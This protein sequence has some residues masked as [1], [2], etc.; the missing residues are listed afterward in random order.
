MDRKKIIAISMSVSFIATAA[1][2]YYFYFQGNQASQTSNATGK[3]QNKLELKTPIAVSNNIENSSNNFYYVQD[4]KNSEEIKKAFNEYTNNKSSLA[5]NKQLSW[6]RIA[7][8][9]KEEVSLDDLSVAVGFKINDKISTLFNKNEYDLIICSPE[10]SSQ[11]YGIVLEVD[12]FNNYPDLYQD[13]VNFMKTWEGSMLS[14][15]HEVLFPGV[16]FSQSELDKKLEFKDGRYRYA[17]VKAGGSMYYE[18]IDD[19]III[20][21]SALCVDK[22]SLEIFGSD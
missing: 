12:L 19:Y 5:Q 18:I 9:E 8:K 21:S 7:N 13:E 6:N 22:T 11:S 15:L 2:F 4:L 17:E 10:N 16:N 3:S 14:D 1:I 20:S